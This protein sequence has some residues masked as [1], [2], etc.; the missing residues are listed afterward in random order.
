MTFIEI[1]PNSDFPIQN[2]PY[3]IF[4]TKEN[5]SPRVC[6]RLGEFVIDLSILDEENLFGKQYNLFNEPSL[7]KF[8][9]A[10][11]NVWKEIR[12]RLTDLLNNNNSKVK[13]EAMHL[14][15]D[16]KLYLPV[17]IGDYTDFY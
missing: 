7:N 8:M 12:G 1:S 9:S 13:K 6:T 3:G 16:V 11:K 2:L 17:N 5:P 10:G 15:K 14:I 4:S